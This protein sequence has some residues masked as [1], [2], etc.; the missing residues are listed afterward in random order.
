MRIA[1]IGWGSLIWDPRSLVLQSRWHKDGPEFGV[2]FARIS[3]DWR[4]TLVLMTNVPKVRTYWA[5]SSCAD[6][7]DAVQNLRHREDTSNKLI[8]G[9]CATGEKDGL[10]GDPAIKAAVQDWLRLKP[11]DA[12]LWA[13][14]QSNWRDVRTKE[15]SVDDAVDY[16]SG[17][18]G[19]QRDR[20]REYVCRA[21]PQT[22]TPLREA[23]EAR[24][25][26]SPA[27]LDP[28]YFE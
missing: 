9:A 16:L 14:L 24:L 7:N 11:L 17:L 23:L 12:A 10:P 8:H 2:E 19:T 21:P 22:S 4:A 25:G 13:G 1:I 15:F 28:G 5:L 20:A 18:K 27:L 26:W 3:D 6:V